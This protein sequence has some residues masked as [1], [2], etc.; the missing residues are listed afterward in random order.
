M[1]NWQDKVTAIMGSGRIHEPL[2]SCETDHPGDGV[3]AAARLLLLVCALGGSRCCHGERHPPVRHVCTGG[4]A[5]RETSI[6]C[7]DSGLGWI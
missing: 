5:P 7:T 6:I 4:R 2:Y 1:Q 3:P